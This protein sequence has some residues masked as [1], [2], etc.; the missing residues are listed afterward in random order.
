MGGNGPDRPSRHLATALHAAAIYGSRLLAAEHGP[1]TTDLPSTTLCAWVVLAESDERRAE[2]RCLAQPAWA[3]LSEAS[4]GQH[5]TLGFEDVQ[6]ER[7][8]IRAEHHSRWL[9]A[10]PQRGKD[11]RRAIR[12]DAH[13]VVVTSK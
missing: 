13:D 8:V 1:S 3:S 11:R 4:N 10:A 6:E 5:G 12:G 9:T 7:A 2:R